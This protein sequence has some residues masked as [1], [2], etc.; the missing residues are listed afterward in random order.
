MTS[1]EQECSKQEHAGVIEVCSIA[2]HCSS[3]V[4]QR[5]R[6]PS[7]DSDDESLEEQWRPRQRFRPAWQEAV[8]SGAPISVRDFPSSAETMNEAGAS[9]LVKLS[10]DD[11]P[12][13]GPQNV[14]GGSAHG[15]RISHREAV[16]SDLHDKGCAIYSTYAGPGPIFLNQQATMLSPPQYHLVHHTLFCCF[17][18]RMRCG[19]Y[20]SPSSCFVLLDLRA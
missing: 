7:R 17:H 18:V 8:V 14:K 2:L 5:G 19:H 12:R 20:L 13:T 16:F 11:E 6:G 9:T 15:N 1:Q 10:V 4:L 3:A